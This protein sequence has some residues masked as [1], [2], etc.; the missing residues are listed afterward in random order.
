MIREFL[1]IL[2]AGF[3]FAGIGIFFV[4]NKKVKLIVGT[5]I[6]T[7]FAFLLIL[8]VFTSGFSLSQLKDLFT[9]K[10]VLKFNKKWFS[11][12]ILWSIFPVDLHEGIINIIMLMPIGLYIGGIFE[13]P[14]KKTTITAFAVSL[15]IEIMQFVLPIERFSQLSDVI[16]NTLGAVIACLYAM[17][18]IWLRKKCIEKRNKNKL[19][20]K[21]DSSVVEQSEQKEKITKN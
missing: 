17:L 4:G 7:V 2:I 19:Q 9:G 3:L 6:F 1:I 20:N 15:F 8:G 12:E 16:L 21:T 13:K 5:I 14:L 11:G 18:I 10:V